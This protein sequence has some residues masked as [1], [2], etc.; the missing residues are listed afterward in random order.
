MVLL[1][2]FVWIE[3]QENKS[4]FGK[5]KKKIFSAVICWSYQ[6]RR[7]ST[8][9]SRARATFRSGLVL[10]YRCQKNQTT[11]SHTLLLS[12][13]LSLIL[14]NMLGKREDGVCQHTCI[15]SFI[16]HSWGW[17]HAWDAHSQTD[18]V[19]SLK[20]LHAFL[21]EAAAW[22]TPLTSEGFNNGLGWWKWFT[23]IPLGNFLINAQLQACVNSLPHV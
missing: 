18:A 19:T 12:K 22:I 16:C 1:C 3:S 8:L 4:T 6:D 5:V 2:D 10:D 13:Q 15:R 9:M 7:P 11:H 17:S 21:G 14:L 20:W 23:N